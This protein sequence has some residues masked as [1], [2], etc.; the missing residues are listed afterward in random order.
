MYLAN[1]YFSKFIFKLANVMSE[2]CT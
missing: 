1:T 2:K